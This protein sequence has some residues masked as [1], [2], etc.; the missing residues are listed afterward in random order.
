MANRNSALS[1][2]RNPPALLGASPSRRARRRA[3]RRQVTYR[4]VT[5]PQ[6][7]SPPTPAPLFR[8]LKQ[9]PGTLVTVRHGLRCAR[10][11][12]PHSELVT[13]CDLV[14]SAFTSVNTA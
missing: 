12:T 10:R 13:N 8:Q 1:L 14:L 11:G 3:E 2:S 9:Q 5:M 6:I 7:S 4:F